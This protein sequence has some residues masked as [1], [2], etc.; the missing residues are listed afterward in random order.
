MSGEYFDDPNRQAVGLEPA[1]AE[2]FG[3]SDT[4]GG[5]GPS[6]A[7]E[8]LPGQHAG[9]DKLAEER[10]HKWSRDDLTVAEKQTELQE[11]KAR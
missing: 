9:M 10:G 8:K 6:K 1:W 4:S 3:G 2:G 5:S 11:D 7:E